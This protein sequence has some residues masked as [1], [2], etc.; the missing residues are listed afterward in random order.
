MKLRMGMVGGGE[1]S[2]IG[3]VHRMAAELDGTIQLVAGAFS[4]DEKRSIRSGTEMYGL[5][6]N[7][8]YNNYKEMLLRESQLP[9]DQRIDF[10]TVVTPNHLHHPV[11]VLALESGFHVVCDKP[12]TFTLPEALDLKVRI[13]QAERIFALTHN[14][15]GYPM[16]REARHLVQIGAL[17]KLRRINVEYIQGWLA[18][19]LEVLGNKQA[20][21]RTDPSRSGTAGCIGDIGTHAFQ[22]AEFT[23]NQKV[24]WLSSDLST[25]VPA[26]RL[27][28][29]GNILLRFE[30]GPK[31]VLC[32]SQ[33]AVGVENNLSIR[34]Y[35]ELGGV[36]W[37]QLEPNS[38]VVRWNDRPFEVRRTGGPGVHEPA[39]EATRLPAG[40][41]E[42]F[43]EAFAVL[44]KNFARAVRQ[45]A[46]G[47]AIGNCEQDFPTIEDGIRGMA[48]IEAAVASS[49]QNSK[50]TKLTTE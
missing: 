16:I 38:L 14:Y 49:Q 3:T 21:W 36:E 17:G 19:R 15:T 43:L 18:D 20:E 45:C 24:E 46:S 4:S 8:C 30:G 27:D 32:A 33:I 47:T 2:F 9:A 25:F 1:G 37:S 34:L 42:G 29:D 26:R 7:R 13:D 5:V 11:A 31:G 12:A 50:W 23:T 40:H 41:P 48:F 39:V 35:G 22:L 44:Y 10:V 28:D 6:P